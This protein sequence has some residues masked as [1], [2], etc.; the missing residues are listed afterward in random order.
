MDFHARYDLLEQ[1]LEY[2]SGKLAELRD[3]EMFCFYVS[4]K[5]RLALLQQRC[6]RKNCPL[7]PHSL[8]WQIYVVG[9]NGKK[10]WLADKKYKIGKVPISIRRKLSEA[11]RRRLEQIE[12]KVKKLM[13]VR[14][15]LIRAK[16]S[17][18]GT[19]SRLPD[20]DDLRV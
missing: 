4:E 1:M 9:K 5:Q 6:S 15:K 13:A 18:S 10:K 19:L 3:E 2:A 16:K 11:N 17:I 20:W 8:Y 7:C 12:G 14:A